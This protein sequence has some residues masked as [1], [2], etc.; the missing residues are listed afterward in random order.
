MLFVRAQRS[1]KLRGP[2]VDFG[3]VSI[4]TLRL[5]CVF[6]RR[7]PERFLLVMKRLLCRRLR[8]KAC[9]CERLSSVRLCRRESA[10]VSECSFSNQLTV[11][12]CHSDVNKTPILP[13]RARTLVRGPCCAA[14]GSRCWCKFKACPTQQ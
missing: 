13:G 14:R 11:T 6:W 1:H 3:P 8:V 2:S 10:S 9:L 5:S 12:L 4:P 7:K